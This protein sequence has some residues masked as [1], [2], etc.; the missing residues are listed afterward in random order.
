[1]NYLTLQNIKTGCIGSSLSQ[2]LGFTG[3][4]GS[5]LLQVL[6]FTLLKILGLLQ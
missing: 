6:G 3:C 2:V 5:S 1:M 4:I